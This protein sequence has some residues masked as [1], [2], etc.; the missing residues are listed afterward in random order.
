[1]NRITVCMSVFLVLCVSSCAQE[2]AVYEVTVQGS[3]FFFKETAGSGITSKPTNSGGILAGFRFN[4]TRWLAFEADYDYFSNSQKYVM[5]TGLT[6]F[7]TNVHNISGSAIFKIPASFFLKPYALVGGAMM[8]FEP[9]GISGLSDQ[10]RGAF[11]YGGGI[12]VPLFRRVAMRA[13]YRGFLYNVPNFD[14]N[15]LRVDKLTHTAVPS[16]GLV[17]TF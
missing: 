3:G 5:T 14:V 12:D 13:Q 10:T 16:A 2:K 4:S 9:H 17:I 6:S 11:V 8:I 7:K 15:A 1:M